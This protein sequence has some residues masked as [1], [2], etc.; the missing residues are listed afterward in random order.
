MQVEQI[1]ICYNKSTKHK[2]RLLHTPPPAPPPQNLHCFWLC[3]LRLNCQ[4]IL[5]Q[6]LH[7][8]RN[9]S[10]DL[11]NPT[12]TEKAV[13]TRSRQWAQQLSSSITTKCLRGGRI[14]RQADRNATALTDFRT[15]WLLSTLLF[16]PLHSFP[17]NVVFQTL[18]LWFFI[19]NQQCWSKVLSFFGNK[20]GMV[21]FQRWQ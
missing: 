3:M 8:V 17:L 2:F 1:N 10:A 13:I 6:I 15:D 12:L 4:V 20:V 14:F 16:Q 19:N 9:M 18:P 7:C 11:K 5:I 21:L